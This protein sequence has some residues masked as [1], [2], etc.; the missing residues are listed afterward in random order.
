MGTQGRPAQPPGGSM[1]AARNVS[2]A[3]SRTCWPCAPKR[4]AS[5]AM[6][7]VLPVPLTP[8]T[9][10]TAGGARGGGGDERLFDRLPGRPV[11]AA[12]EDGVQARDEAAPALLD[13]LREAGLR[14]HGAQPAAAMS[15]LASSRRSEMT[16]LTASSPMVTP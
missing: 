14:R 16:R 11:Q 7:V 9:R 4:A 15:S 5:L 1:A 8:T 3:A 12:A 10:I 13:A 2:A 6:V